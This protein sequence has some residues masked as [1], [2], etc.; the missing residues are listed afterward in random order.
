MWSANVLYLELKLGA[1]ECRDERGVLGHG[2][3][4]GRGEGEGEAGGLGVRDDAV[5]GDGGTAWH[6][7]LARALLVHRNMLWQPEGPSVQW[8]MGECGD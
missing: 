7:P 4:G 5:Q 8:R 6:R 3:H 2:L 1:R